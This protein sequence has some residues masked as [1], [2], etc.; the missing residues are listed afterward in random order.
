MAAKHG[1]NNVVF[2]GEW[3]FFASLKGIIDIQGRLTEPFSLLVNMDSRNPNYDSDY[4][5][6][7]NYLALH[8]D[9]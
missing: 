5:N 3:K 2:F 7:T 4:T 9:H 1:N 6:Y 8:V